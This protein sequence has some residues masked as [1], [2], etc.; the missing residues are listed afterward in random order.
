LLLSGIKRLTMGKATNSVE[1]NHFDDEDDNM[2]EGENEEPEAEATSEQEEEAEV[3]SPRAKRGRKSAKGKTPVV[4][5]AGPKSKTKRGRVAKKAT[6]RKA[7]PASRKS[8]ARK[9][10]GGRGRKPAAK[11]AKE[12]DKEWEVEKI[13]GVQMSGKSKEFLVRWKGWAKATWEPEN[14]LD[15]SQDL[16]SEFIDSLQ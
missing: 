14:N 3:A 16:V 11:K 15:G 7:A 6:P 8:P 5:K 1:E 12:D 13:I 2:N 4:A 10:A 9:S